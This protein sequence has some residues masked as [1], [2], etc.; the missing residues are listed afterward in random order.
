ML[1]HFCFRQATNIDPYSI[2]KV[3][4]IVK[5]LLLYFDSRRSQSNI[6]ETIT[7]TQMLAPFFFSYVNSVACKTRGTSGVTS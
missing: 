2:L 3:N 7:C 4:I 6:F 1:P 5:L